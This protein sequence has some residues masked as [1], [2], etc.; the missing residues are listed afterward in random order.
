[1]D[2]KNQFRYKNLKGPLSTREAASKNYV[3]TLFYHPSIRRNSAR[4]D[5]N[6]KKLDN[7]RL[8][9]VNSMP[10]VGEHLTAKNMLINLF[11]IV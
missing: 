10:A 1:M 4:V 7:V 5:F 11:L 3:D 6:D 2:K 9:R 8:V